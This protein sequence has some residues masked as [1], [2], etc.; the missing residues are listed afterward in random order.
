MVLRKNIVIT[1]ASAGLGASMARHFA[2]AGRNLALC[3]RR[4]DRI[5][6]LA[7]QLTEKH[8]GIRVLTRELDVNDHDR[9]FSVFDEFHAELGGV[10]RVIVNAGLGK[11]QPVGTGYFHANRQTA[12]TNF[13]A[14]LAQSEAAMQMFREA[15]EGHLVFVSSFS[16]L[17]G[18][19]R[20][21]TSYAASKA[22]V[23]AL[24]EGIR[25]D[26][27]N[28]PI[29][30][31]TLLPGFIE[32]EMTRRAG[33]TPLITGAERGGRAMVRAIEQERPRAYV[34][35]LPWAPLSGVI[36]VLPDRLLR[37]IL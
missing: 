7:E 33:R 9:V 14:A 4:Q 1:G 12:Q 24:A 35:T 29:R 31:T 25:I 8:P 13:L 23:S 26:T 34:P 36:R 16:A 19:P 5:D 11:G 27:Q 22:G 32:S 21:M 20:N 37:R 2:A 10:D 15:Q 6:T 30:V 28:T 17:R 18:M 3:A